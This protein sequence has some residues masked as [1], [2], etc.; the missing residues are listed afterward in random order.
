ML[1]LQNLK[2]VNE[3]AIYVVP[4]SLTLSKSIDFF[5]LNNTVLFS[6]IFYILCILIHFAALKTQLELSA[7]SILKWPH[8]KTDFSVNKFLIT[9]FNMHL[10][11]VQCMLISLYYTH[12]GCTRWQLAY[13]VAVAILLWLFM[14][15]YSAEINYK[16][17]ATLNTFLHIVYSL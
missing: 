4:P 13:A 17:M 15:L 1:L 10:E 12:P 7:F 5:L 6:T 14:L 16:S 3:T 11:I 2:L 8:R 9:Y